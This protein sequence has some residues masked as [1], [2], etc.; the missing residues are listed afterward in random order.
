MVQSVTVTK[1]EC[2]CLTCRRDTHIK[3]KEQGLLC[4]PPSTEEGAVCRLIKARKVDK[5]PR[6]HFKSCP[7][8]VNKK[9]GAE[10]AHYFIFSRDGTSPAL[11]DP[12]PTGGTK[13]SKPK[14]IVVE[15]QDV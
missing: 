6:L 8:L 14:T 15:R 1:G 11:N 10:T 9:F 5:I 3:Q 13:C 7:W 4:V 2:H 12:K